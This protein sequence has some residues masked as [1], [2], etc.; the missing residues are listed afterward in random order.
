MMNEL[1]RW[2]GPSAAQEMG[3]FFL[4]IACQFKPYHDRY[5]NSLQDADASLFFANSAL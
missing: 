3:A 2:Y 4:D 5:G 1:R